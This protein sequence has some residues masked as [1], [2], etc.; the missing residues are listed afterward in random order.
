[1]RTETAISAAMQRAG[2]ITSRDARFDVAIAEFQNNG[3]SEEQAIERVRAAYRML[4]EGHGT[5]AE[6]GQNGLANAQHTNGD[7]EAMSNEPIGHQYDASPSPTH[8]EQDGPKSCADEGQIQ[9][10]A[11]VRVPSAQPLRILQPSR[12]PS[13]TDVAAMTTARKA[14]AEVILKIDGIDIRDLTVGFCISMARAKGMQAR[15]LGQLGERLKHLP[16]T[17]RVGDLIH[18]DELKRIVR[19]AKEIA[20]A[21]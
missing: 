9:L 16:H 14:A 3:G 7:G 13:R 12:E 19:D 11:P 10:A 5:S 21:A 18:D 4:G 6:R 1:M 15:V 17:T 20:N 2:G 8:R